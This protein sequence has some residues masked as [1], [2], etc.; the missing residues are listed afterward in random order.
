[1]H[2]IDPLSVT[3]AI[4]RIGFPQRGHRSGKISYKCG[5]ATSHTNRSKASGISLLPLGWALGQAG[6]TPARI[7]P[8]GVGRERSPPHAAGHCGPRPWGPSFQDQLALSRFAP[9]KTVGARTPCELR[10]CRRGGGMRVASRSKNAQRRSDR[11]SPGYRDVRFKLH[12]C[13]RQH[14][15]RLGP[16]N[17]PKSPRSYGRAL[18]CLT[19]HDPR[20]TGSRSQQYPKFRD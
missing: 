7:P 16:M 14:R 4:S 17:G 19:A 1:M 8:S 11:R 9:G 18:A 20:L 10:R 6:S 2:V 5:R 3:K 12:G 13:E 15:P